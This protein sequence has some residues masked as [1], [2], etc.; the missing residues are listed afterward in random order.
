MKMIAGGGGG[1]LVIEQPENNIVRSAYYGLI[2]ALSGTQTMALCSYD[3]AYTIPSEKAALISLRTM[4]MLVDEMGVGDTVD[5]LA[6]SYYVESLT[7]EFEKRITAT[8]AEVDRQGGIV[9]AVAEGYIQAQV[10]A[11][12]YELEKAIQDGAFIK[13]GVNKYRIEEEEERPVEFHEYQ[14]ELAEEQVRRL[15]TIREKRNDS[16]VKEKLL[17]LREKAQGTENL[18]PYIIEAVKVYATVGEIANVFREVFGE[19]DEPVKF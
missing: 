6:G 3:E 1:G 8:M 13:V 15:N 11:Q 14:P 4:Q 5:P 2:S 10:S 17:I 16:E 12:A 7:N 9:K 18:M 19:F